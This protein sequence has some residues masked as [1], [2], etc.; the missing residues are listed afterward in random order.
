MFGGGIRAYRIEYI[1]INLRDILSKSS[2]YRRIGENTYTFP[3]VFGGG[4][5]SG[6]ETTPRSTLLLT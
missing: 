2:V 5:R 3:I 4:I 1:W 6:A